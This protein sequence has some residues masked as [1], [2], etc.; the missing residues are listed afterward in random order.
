[1]SSLPLRRK[2]HDDSVHSRPW[3]DLTSRRTECKSPCLTVPAILFLCSFVASGMCSPNR[4]S[5]M[6]YSSLLSQ[7]RVLA[8]RWLAMDVMSQ[9]DR[10]NRV[11]LDAC[12]LQVSSQCSA[13]YRLTRKSVN[14]KYSLVSTGMF[15]FKPA[16]QRVERDQSALSCALNVE[17]FIWTNF[18]KFS[19]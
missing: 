19:K 16:S 8:G 15:L 7:K 3:T 1:V 17:S 2:N 4:C 9:Y 13:L 12:R 5:A 18:C 11:S 6:D 10:H 14:L